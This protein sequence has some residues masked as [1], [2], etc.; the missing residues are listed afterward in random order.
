[1]KK[2]LLLGLVCAGTASLVLAQ[3]QAP[4]DPLTAGAKAPY[5][6][7]K[8]YLTKSADQVPESLYNYKP[9]PEVRTFGQLFAHVADSNYGFCAGVLGEKVP[10]EG[11]EKTKTTKADLVKALADSFAYCDKAF[12]AVTDAN[13]ATPADFFGRPMARLAI[14]SFNAAHDFEHYGNVV[15]YMRLNKMVPPSSQ[16]R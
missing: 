6:S 15:T 10:V 12:A 16:P 14:L 4:K 7:V 3:A 5:N 8:N 13:A 9:T 11:I 1:M 2:L